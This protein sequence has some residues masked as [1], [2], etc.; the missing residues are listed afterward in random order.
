MKNITKIIRSTNTVLL[1]LSCSVLGFSKGLNLDSLWHEINSLPDDTVKVTLMQ[2]SI[3]DVGIQYPQEVDSFAKF[4][5]HLADSLDFEKGVAKSWYSLGRAKKYNSQYDKALE[6]FLKSSQLAKDINE[7]TLFGD[8]NN[9]IGLVFLNKGDYD[10]A[11]KYF[12]TAK[13]VFYNNSDTFGLMMITENMGLVHTQRGDYAKALEN[14]SISLN[15]IEA[16]NA[17]KGSLNS[18]SNMAELYRKMGEYEKSDSIYNIILNYLSGEESSRQ[19]MLIYT[20]MGALYGDMGKRDTAI[21]YHQKA[22]EIGKKG[23]YTDYIIMELVNLALNHIYTGDL[24]K[25]KDYLDESLL[26]PDS[27]KTNYDLGITY[28]TYGRLY[29]EMKSSKKSVNSYKKG[30]TFL[31][32]DGISRA[33][34][35]AHKKLSQGYEET[36]EY[37]MALESHKTYFQLNDSLHSIEMKESVKLLE[38]RFKLRS[39]EEEVKSLQMKNTLNELTINRQK[40]ERNYILGLLGLSFLVTSVA[41][42][43]FMQRRKTKYLKELNQNKSKAVS[44]RINPHFLYNSL[45]SLRRFLIDNEIEK[46]NNYIFTFSALSRK[47]LEHSEH[48]AIPLNEELNVIMDYVS[49]QQNKGGQSFEFEVVNPDKIDFDVYQIPPNLLQPIVEN[50]FEHA[51]RGKTDTGKIE[52]QVRSSDK[53]MLQILV[54]DNGKGIGE[55]IEKNRRSFGLSLV[56]E[57]LESLSNKL[58]KGKLE[59]LGSNNGTTVSL[60]IPQVQ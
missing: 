25:S 12:L 2:K 7:T 59:I 49:L 36:G 27:L 30:I 14:I 26:I 44:A 34:L 56:K 43:A 48:Y 31:E 20:N 4:T 18:Y 13:E 52:V 22:L 17:Q 57:R 24:R 53:D 32:K 8:A 29:E 21:S 39:K 42:I 41:F 10:I 35:D 6:C 37:K 51:L 5:L 28:V 38:S 60:T 45:N 40:R 23:K 3:Y 15:Y 9:I 58:G 55:N 16:E 54:K 11:E 19:K 33:L 46:A 47:I 1:I 50:C